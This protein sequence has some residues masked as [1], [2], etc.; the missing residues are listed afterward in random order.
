LSQRLQAALSELD[1]Y[2]QD[3]LSPAEAADDLATLM[4]H[5][6]EVVMQRV[7]AWAVDQSQK[8]S[9]AI[10]ELVLHA[11]KK[12]Y[13]LGEL[14][15]LDREAVA[16]YL[17]RLTSFAMRIAPATELDDLRKNLT[18]M[19]RSRATTAVFERLAS[20]TPAPAAAQPTLTLEQATAAKDYSLILDRI[21]KQA[22]S[23]APPSAQSDPQAF[24][25]LLTMAATRAQTGQQFEQYL[26]Q[27]KPYV[28]GKDA[29]VFV[30]LGGGMPSWEMPANVKPGEWK[31]PAQVDAME[32]I[33]DF[34]ED[35]KA[36][37]ARLR[38]LV[39]ASIGKFNEGALGAAVWMLTLADDAIKEKKLDPG[40]IERIRGE[41]VAQINA[42]QLRKYA[43]NKGRHAA[44]RIAL[45]F[46]PSLQIEQLFRRLRGEK[47]AET[48][49]SLLGY[50]EAY[51]VT[52]RELA[53]DELERELDRPDLDT[54]YLRN[55]IYLLHRIARESDTTIPRELAALSRSTERGQNI[56][57]MK[58]AAT[59]IGQIKSDEA[60]SLLATR[61][62]EF[63]D[64]PSLM[65]LAER[66]KLLDRMVGS[67]ARIGTSAALLAIA[68]HG[69]N[70]NAQLG[71]ARARLAVLA[72]HDLSFDQP[73][74][75]VLLKALRDELP[76]KLF[77]R[78]K[79]TEPTVHLINALSG[80][81]DPDVEAALKDVA[82]RFPDQSPKA[83][84]RQQAPPPPKN[85]PVATLTGELEFFG[86]TSI[87]QSISDMRYSGMLTL[88]NK[89][90]QA[91]SKLVFLDGK[92][93][94]A[95][96]GHIR[97]LDALYEALEIPVAGSFAFVPYPPDRLQSGIE[98]LEIVGLLLEGIR[99]ND[100][101]QRLI[102]LVPDHMAFGKGT[103]KP[104]PAEEET[105]PA[106]IRE[107]WLKASSGGKVGDFSRELPIDTFRI[108]RQVAHWLETGALVPV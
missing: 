82:Q 90:K 84:A 54:Y 58:E 16:N 18:E 47:Q 96:T 33:I 29:N 89:Q 103:A 93:V 86:L 21:V 73:T 106:F 69:M 26:E 44:V 3:E 6:P 7:A 15:L 85:E 31:A 102:A 70:G 10:G 51:G 20:F 50:V 71:D 8:R 28:G 101:L 105:D 104:T 61:L 46:F 19:R 11:M 59:A 4:A 12:V 72:Q 49:R 24:A 34:A 39:N 22:G 67:L 95:Q 78:A 66:Y 30:I 87:M 53:L 37:T 14:G 35:S 80:T 98:P 68:R 76:S 57:V 100:E 94:N 75:D 79:M 108:R 97:G 91:T 107:V 43:E 63:E 64:D 13:I 81:R 38:D 40:D 55:L 56:Y 5:P 60:V 17:D 32:K 45:E 41:A 25:Q 27:L 62:A 88:T 1:R 92:F 99:R 65:P 48:R 74:V 83:A 77:G 23:G 42:A 52:G 2:L 9:V 36:A